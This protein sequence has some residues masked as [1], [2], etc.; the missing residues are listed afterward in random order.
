MLINFD[1]QNLSWEA[2]S[3]ADSQETPYIFSNQ[4]VNFRAQETNPLGAMLTWLNPIHIPTSYFE[5]TF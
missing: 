4:N 5:D 3:S 1:E 2:N